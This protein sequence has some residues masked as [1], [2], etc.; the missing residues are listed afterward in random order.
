MIPEIDFESI[1]IIKEYPC[2]A[3]VVA[4]LFEKYIQPQI[5]FDLQS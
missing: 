2:G 3:E 4:N 5:K 1:E